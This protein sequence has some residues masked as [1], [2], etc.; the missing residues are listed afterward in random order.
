MFEQTI[1]L[2]GSCQRIAPGPGQLV[3]LASR[4]ILPMRGTF[5]FPLRRQIPGVLQAPQRRVHRYTRH[6]GDGADVATLGIAVG[7]GIE[8]RRGCEGEKS[9]GHA[10][11]CYLRFSRFNTMAR[12]GPWRSSQILISSPAS[13][14]ATFSVRSLICAV[15]AKVFFETF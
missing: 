7:H 10:S 4:P 14:P 12:S 6:T 1:P 11:S 8:N 13:S 9:L 2:A 15:N 5:R 3:V